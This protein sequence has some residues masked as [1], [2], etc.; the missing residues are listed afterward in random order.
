MQIASSPALDILLAQLHRGEA[1]AI[2]LAGHVPADIL[3]ID[4]QDGRQF[5]PQMGL[6]VTGVL[7]VLLRAKRS[8]DIALLR[9]EIDALRRR[10]SQPQENEDTRDSRLP[11]SSAGKYCS[12]NY[13]TRVS[14]SSQHRNSRTTQLTANH[15]IA[16]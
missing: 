3:L 2:S 14:A 5:A 8:G 9:T 12:A 6:A 4:E 1:E 15:G 16:R 13:V 7:G 11:P 10:F